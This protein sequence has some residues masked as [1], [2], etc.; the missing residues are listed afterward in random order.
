MDV[1]EA[2]RSM[3]VAQNTN[4]IARVPGVRQVLV[5][6]QREIGRRIGSLVTEGR[7]QGSVV[8][9]DADYK[10]IVDAAD[11]K[12]AER[13]Y[14]DLTADGES[15]N[16]DDVLDNIRRRDE[17]DRAQWAPLLESGRAIQIDTTQLGIPAV[18]EQ[19]LEAI[20]GK[21]ATASARPAPV[22]GES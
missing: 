11:F 20:R 8:F 3:R 15:V 1:S 19:M 22:D 17:N 10:F 21:G 14:I 9:P 12:R 2:I 5:E 6:K 7:D 16:Y 4:C 18:V 13:R